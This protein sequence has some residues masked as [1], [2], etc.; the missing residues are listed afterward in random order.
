MTTMLFLI[1]SL[2]VAEQGRAKPVLTPCARAGLQIES[3]DVHEFQE[4]LQGTLDNKCGEVLARVADMLVA[5]SAPAPYSAADT[6]ALSAPQYGPF[7]MR[8]YLN[9]PLERSPSVEHPNSIR[10]NVLLAC[11]DL[12][13]G[14]DLNSVP[15]YLVGA[16]VI[17]KSCLDEMRKLLDGHFDNSDVAVTALVLLQKSATPGGIDV[18]E[19]FFSAGGAGIRDEAIRALTNIPLPIAM[20]LLSRGLNDDA[21]I[22]R[23]QAVSVLSQWADDKVRSMMEARLGKEKSQGI[24]KKIQYYLQAIKPSSTDAE[25]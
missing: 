9:A 2:L 18:V 6:L 15:D 14:T 3:R 13:R 4:G 25:R 17:S 16:P 21:E 12:P 5:G 11:S 19:K 8:L 7:L 23:Y 22:V 1:L 20:P 10:D 24:R